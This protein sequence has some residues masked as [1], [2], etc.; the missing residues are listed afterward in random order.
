[1]S[2]CEKDQ[3]TRMNWLRSLKPG[4]WAALPE[5]SGWSRQTTYALLEVQRVTATLVICVAPGSGKERRFDRRAGYEKG[6]SSRSARLTPVTVEV[7][8]ANELA[9]LRRWFGSLERTYPAGKI[10]LP[11]L[12]ALKEAFTRIMSQK[13]DDQ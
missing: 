6:A 7:T 4:D 10:D 8:E 9:E 5:Q 11:K 12:R 2:E 3:A 1:M 13:A